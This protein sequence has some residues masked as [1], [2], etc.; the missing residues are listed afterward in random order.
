M[1]QT[2]IQEIAALVDARLTCLERERKGSH[3]ERK[4][5]HDGADWVQTHT[6]RLRALARD[7]LPSGSGLD[8]G[9]EIDLERS[10]GEKIVLTTSYHHMNEAG[11]YDGWTDHT[12]TVRASLVHGIELKISGRDRGQIKDHL[13]ELYDAALTAPTKGNGG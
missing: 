9:T 13:A 4:G 7:R 2:L 5:A 6:E 11:L 1:Q 3:D 10:T 8:S 12:I